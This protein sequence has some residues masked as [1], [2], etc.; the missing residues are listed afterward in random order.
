MNTTINRSEVM[1]RAWNIFRSGHSFY[2]INFSVAL[3]RAWE[4]EKGTIQYNRKKAEEAAQW[5]EWKGNSE[6]IKEIFNSDAHKTNFYS[7][8]PSGAYW[9][10]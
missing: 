7:N 3:R 9:G 6:I 1:K 5:N 2:S 8:M 10:S 4:V